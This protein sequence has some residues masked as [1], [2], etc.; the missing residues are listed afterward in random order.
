MVIDAKERFAQRTAQLMFTLPR[1][2]I[3]K[4]FDNFDPSY[5]TLVLQWARKM[6]AQRR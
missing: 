6:A 5:I 3:E 4:R 2:E 1:E